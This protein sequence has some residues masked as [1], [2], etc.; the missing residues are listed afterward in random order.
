MANHGYCKNCYW[1]N[2][3]EYSDSR[4]NEKFPN[5]YCGMW[6]NETRLNSYCPDYSRKPKQKTIVLSYYG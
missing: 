3:F 4:D 6:R 1:F 2:N 5:G